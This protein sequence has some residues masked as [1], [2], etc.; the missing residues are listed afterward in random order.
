M[1]KSK[2]PI[3][4]NFR[5]RLNKTLDYDVMKNFTIEDY[6][7]MVLELFEYLNTIR[8]QGVKKDDIVPIVDKIYYNQS[9]FF[10]DV[11][12]ERRFTAITDDFV[13]FGSDPMFWSEDY[14]TYIRK[15][16]KRLESRWYIDENYTG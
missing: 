3:V 12:F 15:W 13:G 11:L 8:E 6:K 9:D 16:N 2:N 10:D 7:K 14:L 1:A 4:Q 5:T